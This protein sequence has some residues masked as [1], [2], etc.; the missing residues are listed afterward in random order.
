[1]GE[2][3]GVGVGSAV[4]VVTAAVVADVS[5]GGGVFFEQPVTGHNKAATV[6]V[7]ASCISLLPVSLIL[8]FSECA[9]ISYTQKQE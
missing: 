4:V 6:M 9:F 3:D 7:T 1:M 8:I 2:G 5:V